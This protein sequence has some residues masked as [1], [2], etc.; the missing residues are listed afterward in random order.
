MLERSAWK[1]ARSVPRGLLLRQ[2]RSGYSTYSAEKRFLYETEA[3][4]NVWKKAR[5]LPIILTEVPVHFLSVYTF[6]TVS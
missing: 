4:G 3:V 6:Y 1:Q 5:Y 2:L